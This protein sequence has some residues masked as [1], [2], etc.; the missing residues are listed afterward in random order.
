MTTEN[1]NTA[2]ETA[3][4]ALT[5]LKEYLAKM[6]SKASIELPTD[7]LYPVLV[8]AIRDFEK[9]VEIDPLPVFLKAIYQNNEFFAFKVP[10][11]A[12]VAGK[13]CLVILGK[14]YPAKFLAK[15]KLYKFDSAGS[16]QAKNLQ[17]FVFI[18]SSDN[19]ETRA[20]AVKAW[21]DTSETAKL[22]DTSLLKKKP[23]YLLEN[24]LEYI[25]PTD[26][27]SD[28]IYTVEAFGK[29][30]NRF[31]TVR[32]DGKLY[33]SKEKYI[34]QLQARQAEGKSLQFVIDGV[35]TATLDDGTKI[36]YRNAYV[37][38]F[39]PGV[40]LKALIGDY[41]GLPD[42]E[43]LKTAKKI[44]FEAPL[45]L[46][47][48]NVSTTTVKDKVQHIITCQTPDGKMHNVI[49]N[50][51]LRKAIDSG[52]FNVSTFDGFQIH[53]DSVEFYN[54]Y[55]FNIVYTIPQV[56]IRMDSVLSGLAATLNLGTTAA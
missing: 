33:H 29:T 45:T 27:L 44:V 34:T 8:Q 48:K 39:A 4:Q 31:Y 11:L 24:L 50:T 18:E 16:Q 14:A 38:G 49:P 13:P 28:G 2:P 23:E 30:G 32:I 5:L 19:E 54:G 35:R 41:C 3:T 6:Q 17:Y 46:D 21:F 36:E 12:M 42:E 43:D 7:A 53:I 52:K 15:P 25:F 26:A 51:T 9:T 1:I 10:E 40:Y 56:A 37:E 47:V 20:I 22:L 55:K